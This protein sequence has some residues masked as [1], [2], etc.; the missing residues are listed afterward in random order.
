MCDKGSGVSAGILKP[1]SISL[2]QQQQPKTFLMCENEWLQ[3]GY[4]VVEVSLKSSSRYW[5]IYVSVYLCCKCNNMIIY[6]WLN[7]CVCVRV[8]VWIFCAFAVLKNATLT[9]SCTHPGLCE[10]LMESLVAGACFWGWLQKC[11][12]EPHLLTHC[13][14]LDPG[15][16]SCTSHKYFSCWF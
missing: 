4:W 5:F 15:L 3:C 12:R 14:P 9:H 2:A 16:A 8:H 10:S 13:S 11:F 1:N 7:I 6:V